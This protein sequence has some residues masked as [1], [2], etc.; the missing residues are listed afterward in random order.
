VVQRSEIGQESN[1]Q[2]LRRPESSK[3][4]TGLRDYWVTDS[5]AR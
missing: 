1:L 3:E 4:K 5:F 2:T